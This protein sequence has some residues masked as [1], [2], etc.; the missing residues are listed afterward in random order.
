MPLQTEI[1]QHPPQPHLLYYVGQSRKG[2]SEGDKKR[3]SKRICEKGV[4]AEVGVR[5]RYFRKSIIGCIYVSI[6]T[7]I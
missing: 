7:Y 6:H 5:N 4:R 2:V 1:F 3:N